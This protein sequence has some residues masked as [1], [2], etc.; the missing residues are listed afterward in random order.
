MKVWIID[1]CPCLMLLGWFYDYTVMKDRLGFGGIL[2]LEQIWVWTLEWKRGKWMTSIGFFAER[3]EMMPLGW[4]SKISEEDKP[5]W[6]E[7]STI[8]ISGSKE[9][10][11]T[12]EKNSKFHLLKSEYKVFH[13]VLYT[14]GQNTKKPTTTKGPIK[15]KQKH[16]KNY[17]KSPY[18]TIWS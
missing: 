15:H 4:G 18:S 7:D 12:W 2:G 11:K 10:L 8:R 3:E 16:Y 14:M 17:K 5:L 13:K 9:N 6:I 1:I